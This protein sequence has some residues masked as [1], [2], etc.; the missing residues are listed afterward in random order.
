M[1]LTLRNKVKIISNAHTAR[2]PRSPAIS[3]FSVSWCFF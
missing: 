2:L 3:F 1:K